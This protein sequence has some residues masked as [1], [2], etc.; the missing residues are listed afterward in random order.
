MRAAASILDKIDESISPCED[1]YSFA[2]NQYIRNTIIPEDKSYVDSFSVVRDSLQNQ[3]QTIITA[4]IDKEDIAPFKMMKKLYAACMNKDLVEKLELLPIQNIMREMGG[5][6]VVEGNNWT[7]VSW[8]WQK[9]AVD[10]REHG[11]STDYVVD[12][13]VGADLKN[14]SMRIVDVSL[15]SFNYKTIIIQ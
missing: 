12:F 7:D 8:T 15:M 10:C 1:F 5:W 3:L 13:S 6:P 4:P 11:Y 2:C 14:S 9:A